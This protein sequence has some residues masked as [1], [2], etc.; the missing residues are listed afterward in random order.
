MQKFSTCYALKLS[1]L[2][3]SATEQLSLTLQAKDTT[4]Q[5]AVQA[6]KLAVN[7]LERQRA[8][9]AFD[10]FYSQVLNECKDFTDEPTL[11]CQRRAPKRIDSGSSACTFDSPKSSFRKAY[12]EVLDTAGGELQQW[13][14][15]KRGMPVA[16]ALE[17]CY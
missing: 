17:K 12:Y 3:F 8:D 4:M 9:D 11:P 13:F 16:A 14:H 10:A 15:K 7:F 1:Y 2:V 5:E 6:S